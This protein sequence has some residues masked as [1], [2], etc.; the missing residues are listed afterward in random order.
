LNVADE[1]WGAFFDERLG[2]IAMVLGA[3][4][5]HSAGRRKDR[6]LGEEMAQLNHILAL[7]AFR[8]LA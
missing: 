6:A 1:H 3:A 4:G 2:Y 5:L 8:G 7:P